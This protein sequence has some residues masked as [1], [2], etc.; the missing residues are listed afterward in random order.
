MF[1]QVIIINDW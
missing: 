1:T